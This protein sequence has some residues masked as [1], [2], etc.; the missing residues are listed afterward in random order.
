M[1]GCTPSLA[2]ALTNQASPRKKGL[3]TTRSSCIYTFVHFVPGS[4]TYQL[5]LIAF[6]TSSFRTVFLL[7]SYAY[8]SAL[9]AIF[10]A[11]S[12]R[13]L[14]SSLEAALETRSAPPLL[15]NRSTGGLDSTTATTST[16]LLECNYI[17]ISSRVDNFPFFHL[18]ST[19]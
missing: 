18:F 17:N 2:P 15:I 12:S 9:F 7:S 8:S 10:T 11:Y 3:H 14:A 16:S 13:S 1:A 19:A 6:R 5:Y 4:F